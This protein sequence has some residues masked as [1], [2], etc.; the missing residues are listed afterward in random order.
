MNNQRILVTGSNGF[1]GSALSDELCKRNY[2]VRNAVRDDCANSHLSGEL[3]Y[4]HDINSVTDWGSVLNDVDIVV[5]LIGRAHIMDE[6]SN[7]P[8]EEFRTVNVGATESIAR[9]AADNGVKR[10]LYLS[11]I[12]V[13]GSRSGE[14]PLTEQSHFAPHSPYAVSKYEAEQALH[15]VTSETGLETVIL[16]PPLVYGPGNPGNFLRLLRFVAKGIPLPFSS[17]NNIRSMIYIDNLVDAIIACMFHPKAAGQTYLVSDSDNV[18][19]PQMIRELAELMGRAPR[20]WRLPPAI[21]RLS[22][23]ISGKSSEFESLIGDLAVD[24]RKICE[25]LDWTP[26][27]TRYEGFSETVKWFLESNH[28]DSSLI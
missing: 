15:R 27:F 23:K 3:V 26:P 2:K 22:G 9:A 16:R 7:D 17:I 11:S 6:T 24:N 13:L 20:L 1:I 18:S 4:I 14:S 8:L 25:Q 5:H 19:T 10:F 12:G 21:L 28:I